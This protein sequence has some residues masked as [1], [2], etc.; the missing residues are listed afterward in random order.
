MTSVFSRLVLEMKHFT[1]RLRYKHTGWTVNSSGLK[2]SLFPQ[3]PTTVEMFCSY[4]PVVT[5]GYGACYNPQSDHIIFS[6]SSFHESSQTCSAEFVKSLVQGLLDM[7][8]LCNKCN[9]GLKPTQ[10]TQG[11]TL[12]THTQTDSNWPNKTPEKPN[13]L[14]KNQQTLPQVVLK[15]PDQTKVEAQTQTPSQ[16]EA[17][18][19][20]NGRKA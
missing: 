20:K 8:D 17:Q 14:S 4:G 7:R 6:V 9:Y 18:P 5:N 15:T 13:D 1:E 16:V 10:Q 19:L 2:Y 3:V 11:Q 12:E